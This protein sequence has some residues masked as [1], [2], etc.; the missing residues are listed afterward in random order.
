MGNNSNSSHIVVFITGTVI[1]LIFLYS[2]HLFWFWV[3]MVI[4]A[5]ISG[6]MWDNV[7]RQ[8]EIEEEEEEE[9]FETYM[10]QKEIE[11]Q[12]PIYNAE[13]EKLIGKYG[14]PD[15]TIVL[16]ELN[17]SKEIIA[18]GKTN[19]IW[20][21][22]RDLPMEDIISCNYDDNPRVIKGDVSY[23]TKT[24]MGN[25]A[26]RAIV[27]GILTGGIGAV[28]G[29]ATAKKDTIMKQEDDEII[30]DYTININ[31]NNLSE[32][33]IRIPLGTDVEKANE[34]LGLMNVIIN[35]RK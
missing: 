26:K 19:R 7:R 11:K 30:H 32:P 22:G 14:E 35:R 1:A 18:F 24:R 3:I 16:E 31:I 29:G 5:G 25:M 34:V 20:L 9:D 10:K 15:K 2:D 8:K 21:L 17:L 27:G 23:E 13:K 6:A 28:V 33:I 12:T 4:T